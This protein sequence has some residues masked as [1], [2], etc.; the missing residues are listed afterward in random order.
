MKALNLPRGSIRAIILLTVLLSFLMLVFAV[1]SDL[2]VGSL[3][4]LVTMVVKEYFHTREKDKD[5]GE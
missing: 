2:L 4:S 3:I 1:R 5:K